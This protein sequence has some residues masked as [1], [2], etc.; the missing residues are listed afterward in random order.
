MAQMVFQSTHPHGVR[1]RALDE[2]TEEAVSIHTPA[3]GATQRYQL[4][5]KAVSFQSTHPHGVRL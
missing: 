1:R 2:L 5:N 3:R 4:V